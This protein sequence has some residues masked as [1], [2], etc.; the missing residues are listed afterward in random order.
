MAE[1]N[2]SYKIS[3]SLLLFLSLFLSFPSLS[4]AHN[5]QQSHSITAIFVF[6]DSTVDPGNNNYV[7]TLFRSN[8]PPY[9]RDYTRQRPTGRFTNG[10]L[11]TDFV[12]SYMGLKDA[13]PPYLDKSLSLEELMTG[14]SFASA[15]SGYDPLTPKLGEVIDLPKQL[16]Y[17]REYKKRLELMIGKKRADDHIQRSAVIVSAGTNDF[18]V[19]YFALPFRKQKYTVEEYQYFLLLKFGEFIQGLRD[20]GPWKIAVA[21]LPPMGCLPIVITAN[22][23]GPFQKRACVD[24][25]NSVAQDYNRKL[26]DELGAIQ[27]RCGNEGCRFVYVDIYGPTADMILRPAKFGFEDSTDGCCGTGLFEASFLCSPKSPMCPD[28]SKYVFFDSIHPTER[29]YYILFNALRDTV[30]LLE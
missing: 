18:V 17:F 4:P 28:A 3:P 12:A 14:V 8:F 19:N 21:G 6:G 11:L 29:A 16:D 15:G 7:P 20:L 23:G 30:D 22:R 5:Q 27:K 25:L 2:F 13:I 10:R 26:Q 24:A 1:E 9:G